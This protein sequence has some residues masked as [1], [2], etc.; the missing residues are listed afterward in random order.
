MKSMI[1]LEMKNADIDLPLF[2]MTW[3]GN[4]INKLRL[5]FTYQDTDVSNGLNNVNTPVLII[6]SKIDAITPDA[7][8]KDIHWTVNGSEHHEIWIDH[9]QEYREMLESF[10]SKYELNN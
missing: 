6:Y 7:I 4:I 2:Y 8:G 10:L 9:N 5:G 3:C 1:E